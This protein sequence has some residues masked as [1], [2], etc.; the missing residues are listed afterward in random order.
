V[1]HV[2]HAPVRRRGL[3]PPRRQRHRRLSRRGRR[4]P[5]GGPVVVVDVVRP[6]VR[7]DSPRP[8]RR[9]R[10]PT[11]CSGNGGGTGGWRGGR[12]AVVVNRT[13]QVPTRPA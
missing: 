6:T 1:V 8:P 10:P 5:R 13:L 12:A 7:R 3:L 11:G 9:Q 2:V 4:G